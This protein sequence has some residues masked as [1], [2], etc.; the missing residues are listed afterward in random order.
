VEKLLGDT[1]NVDAGTT[2]TPFSS[3]GRRS[4]IV[5]KSSLG[6]ELGGSLSSSNTSGSTT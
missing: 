5:S 1:T 2:K 3:L 6:S 4:D